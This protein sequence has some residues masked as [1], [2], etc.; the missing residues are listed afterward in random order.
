[1]ILV[2]KFIK[3]NLLKL[4]ELIINYRIKNKASYIKRINTKARIIKTH[5]INY[6]FVVNLAE[7]ETN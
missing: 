1:M 6:V 3:Y 2:S 7:C 4:F 5:E